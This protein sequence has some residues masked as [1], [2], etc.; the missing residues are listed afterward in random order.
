MY[1]ASTLALY[2][3]SSYKDWNQ[4]LY[5]K[6]TKSIHEEATSMIV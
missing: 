6:N 3:L 5:C 1:G 4:S 2:S